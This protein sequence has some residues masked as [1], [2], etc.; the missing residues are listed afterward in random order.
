MVDPT[1]AKC[2]HCGAQRFVGH[3][4]YMNSHDPITCECGEYIFDVDF[5]PTEFEKVEAHL[6]YT[7]LSQMFSL[8]GLPTEDETGDFLYCGQLPASEF[9]S[10]LDRLEG[11]RFYGL[12]VDMVALAYRL[13][14]GI[15]WG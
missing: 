11:S 4:E 15:S 7:S 12:M 10:R 14:V 8:M 2:E 13:E 1:V 6:S 5:Y 9:A 3:S